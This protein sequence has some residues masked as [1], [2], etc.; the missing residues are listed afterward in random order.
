MSKARVPG[1]IEQAVAHDRDAHGRL[2]LKVCLTF[3]L[4]T[5]CATAV[6]TSV[7]LL[8]G[9]RLRQNVAVQMVSPCSARPSRVAR[10]RCPSFVATFPRKMMIRAVFT[11]S[12]SSNSL[13]R[14]GL[15]V[16][17]VYLWAAASIDQG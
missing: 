3:S 13:L 14:W 15:T 11:R 1:R 12:L 9:V 10:T 6:A 5:A 8:A 17:R 4:I 7:M 16:L 2:A